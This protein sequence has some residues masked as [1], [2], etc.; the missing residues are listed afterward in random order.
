[1]FIAYVIVA[2]LLS[3]VLL[4]SA[5]AKFTRPKRLVAQMSTLALPDSV[6]PFLGVAQIAGAVGLI[7]GSWWGPMGIAAAVGVT[8]YF[9]GAVAAHLRVKDF[10]GMPPAAALAVVSVVVGLL[11]TAT[12]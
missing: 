1:M 9:V 3:A 11:R 6:L 10:T 7:A 8:L 12:L 4:S 2:A 5:A